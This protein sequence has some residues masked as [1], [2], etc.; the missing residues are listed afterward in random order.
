MGTTVP[1]VKS[2]L[3]RARGRIPRDA[4]EA[5][6]APEI[7]ARLRRYA[8]LFDA[9]DWDALRA[10]VTEESR[11]DLVSRTQRRGARVA[12][13]WSRYEEIAPAERLRAVPGWVDGVAAIA[14]FRDGSDRP[15]YFMRIEWDGDRIAHIRDYRHVPTIADGARFTPDVVAS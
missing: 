5:P 13:Y 8:Q 1:A 14:M 6:R 7:D 2:A 15:A 4:P 11:L 12:E 3:L 10:L 9:R